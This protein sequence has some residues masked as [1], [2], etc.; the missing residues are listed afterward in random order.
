MSFISRADLV[1]NPDFAEAVFFFCSQD[2]VYADFCDRFGTSDLSLCEYVAY[3]R[4]DDFVE[5]YSANYSTVLW[6]V[7]RNG[8]ILSFRSE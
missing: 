7:V 6:K 5:W 4:F 2:D 1:S 3:Y 8:N